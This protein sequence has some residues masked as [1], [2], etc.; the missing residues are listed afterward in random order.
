M[1]C[2]TVQEMMMDK[3]DDDSCSLL[4]NALHYNVSFRTAALVVCDGGP[5]SGDSESL[6]V[7]GK[8]C[9]S[10]HQTAKPLFQKA[11]R[12]S[13]DTPSRRLYDPCIDS[14]GHAM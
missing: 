5:S 8:Q 7:M 2:I 1:T 13:R 9:S 3:G 14:G 12:K 11:Q 10:R 6:V 4:L